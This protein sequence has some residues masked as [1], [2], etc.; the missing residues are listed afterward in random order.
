LLVEVGWL[1]VGYNRGYTLRMKTAISIP[2]SLYNAAERFAQRM[3]V[4]RSE[5]YQVAVRE[6]LRR[7]RYSAV[8]EAL[9][10][11][12]GSGGEDSQVDPHLERLQ[13]DALESTDW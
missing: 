8:T 12:Y 9:D 10:E 13:L 3:G 2:D 4:S 6:Y 5:L 11:V 7:H 1:D